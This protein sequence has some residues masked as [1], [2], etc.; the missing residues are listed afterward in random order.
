[1]RTAITL[2]RCTNFV[3]LIHFFFLHKYLYLV[4]FFVKKEWILAISPVT[5]DIYF[6]SPVPPPKKTIKVTA[7]ESTPWLIAYPIFSS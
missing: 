2:G 4:C 6:A 7:K 1:M 3:S 5:Y